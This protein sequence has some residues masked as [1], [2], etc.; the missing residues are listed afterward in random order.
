MRHLSDEMSYLA[1]EMRHLAREMRGLVG[2]AYGRKTA[3]GLPWH[4]AFAAATPLAWY[5]NT[6]VWVVH[7][8]AITH[9][10]TTP[11]SG[12]GHG[13]DRAVRVHARLQ[14]WSPVAVGAL[15]PLLAGRHRA[16][17]V[18]GESARRREGERGGVV[19]P[20]GSALVVKALA[21]AVPESAG[22]GSGGSRACGASAEERGPSRASGAA[23]REITS[24]TRESIVTSAVP[25]QAA[26]GERGRACTS[27]PGSSNAHRSPLR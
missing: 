11:A 9:A 24:F 19:R 13:P 26:A 23:S 12:H 14:E 5:S 2:A 16:G 20:L 18:G 25:H 10:P 17:V 8:A 7:A 22:G 4:V 1:H 6:T 15:G 21:G 3:P 27:R